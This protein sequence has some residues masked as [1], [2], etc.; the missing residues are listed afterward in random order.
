MDPFQCYAFQVVQDLFHFFSF[1]LPMYLTLSLLFFF[2]LLL[3]FFSLFVTYC[4][5]FYFSSF[6]I[7]SL[8]LLSA[9]SFFRSPLCI[10]FMARPVQSVTTKVVG[11]ERKQEKD[12]AIITFFVPSPLSL[13]LIL[14]PLHEKLCFKER[15][16]TWNHH[17]FY[18][19]SLLLPT[20]QFTFLWKTEERDG[21]R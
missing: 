11:E 15:F 17:S 7:S 9:S 3:L 18:Y 2:I 13:S 21:E 10:F 1:L 16:R 5:F 6:I 20:F 14:F 4:F 12:V 19:S 8:A